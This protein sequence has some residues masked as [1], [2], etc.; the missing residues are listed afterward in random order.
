MTFYS[1]NAVDQV[2]SKYRFNKLIRCHNIGLPTT[3]CDTMSSDVSCS[4][5]LMFVMLCCFSM[6][7]CKRC[8]VY[9]SDRYDV[10]EDQIT[11]YQKIFLEDVESVE[12]GRLMLNYA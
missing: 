1:T 7:Y 2:L 3:V 5:R 9:I 6:S 12:I 8:C 4:L 11:Q 10:D